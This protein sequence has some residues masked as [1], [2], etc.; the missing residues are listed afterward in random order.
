MEVG[1][2]ANDDDETETVKQLNL[3][4]DTSADSNGQMEKTKLHNTNGSL[5]ESKCPNVVETA[6]KPEDTN[7]EEK[8]CGWLHHRAKGIGNLRGNRQRW[9]V[10]SEENCKLYMYR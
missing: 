10:F 6:K 2:N 8:L 1:V 7:P 9:F 3:Q 4:D 5:V